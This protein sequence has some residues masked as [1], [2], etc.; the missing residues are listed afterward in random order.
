MTSASSAWTDLT[1]DDRRRV[2]ESVRR[3]SLYASP[4]G[5]R[6]LWDWRRDALAVPVHRRST[7]DIDFINAVPPPAPA[8][9]LREG[10]APPRTSHRGADVT[11]LLPVVLL[12][13]AAA[14]LWYGCIL[15]RAPGR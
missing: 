2:L 12:A 4:S 13:L 14:A 8:A 11:F 5:Q 10:F 1:H 6:R 7:V 15:P 9:A 3:G